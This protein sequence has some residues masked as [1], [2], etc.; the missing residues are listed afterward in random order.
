MI[1][2]SY[3]KSTEFNGLEMIHKMADIWQVNAT[4]A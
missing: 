4:C 2:V 1:I 3:D